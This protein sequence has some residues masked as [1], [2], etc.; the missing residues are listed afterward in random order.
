M[1]DPVKYIDIKR[2][3]AGSGSKRLNSL[4]DFIT[5]IIA[6]I[7]CQDEMNR[8]MNKYRDKIGNEFLPEVI[9]ELKINI[10]VTGIENLPENGRCFFVA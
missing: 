7:I 5:R 10:E 1:T 8:I 4:P 9:N 6:K 3:L 2:I